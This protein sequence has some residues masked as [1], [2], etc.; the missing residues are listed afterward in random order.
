M[1]VSSVGS[2]NSVVPLSA[3]HAIASNSSPVPADRFND[4]D[5][6]IGDAQT[7]AAGAKP[8]PGVGQ[9]IDISA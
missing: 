4:G 5:G 2:P 8:S 3:A 6:D 1:S 7:A 9:V